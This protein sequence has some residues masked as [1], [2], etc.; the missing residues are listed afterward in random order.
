MSRERI[1]SPASR[2]MKPCKKPTDKTLGISE[3][4]VILQKERLFLL[5]QEEHRL[6][7][8]LVC[9]QESKV[10]STNADI[11]QLFKQYDAKGSKPTN[12]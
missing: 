8:H 11:Y 3:N 9:A 6:N 1:L 2:E 12:D 10:I 7:R 4:K 5:L